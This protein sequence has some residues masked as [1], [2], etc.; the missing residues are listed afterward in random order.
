MDNF[1]RL[2]FNKIDI[3]PGHGDIKRL[4]E[5]K[6]HWHYILLL[7]IAI[8][9]IVINLINIATITAALKVLKKP[10]DEYQT[11][12]HLGIVDLMMGVVT[13]PMVLPS[14]QFYMLDHPIFCVIMTLS[15]HILVGKW[16]GALIWLAQ[17]NTSFI[18][19]H[20]HHIVS[21]LLTD[22]GRETNL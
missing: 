12:L 6:L 16:K 20:Y 19:T 10:L 11:F 15:L 14:F 1:T 7:V 4:L 2:Q 22:F 18:F 13:I 5:T 9:A 3:C 21:R 8:I 17:C